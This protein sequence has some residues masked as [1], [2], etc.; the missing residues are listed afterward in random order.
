[1]AQWKTKEKVSFSEMGKNY[2]SKKKGGLEIKDLK[3]MNISLL[4]KWWW[5]LENNEG[6]WQNIFKLKR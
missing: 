1:L 6:I 5:R 3:K 2:K 4:C